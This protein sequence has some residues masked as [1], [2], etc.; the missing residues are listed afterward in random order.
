[1]NDEILTTELTRQFEEKRDT[2][3]FARPEPEP[4]VE[5]GVAAVSDMVGN[6]L[7]Q[8]VVHQIKNNAELQDQMLNTAENCIKTEMQTVA[9]DVDT[10]HKKAVFNN[11]K[12]ACE[13]YGFN[14]E[15]TPIWAVNF[16]KVGYSIILAIWLLVGSFTFM[17]VIFIAKKISVGLKKT[18]L[19]VLI[20]LVLYLGV[21]FVPIIVA[22]LQTL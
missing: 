2:D 3:L 18:W 16:M 4:K 12:D 13:S 9:T 17:P 11:A 19:A 22:L 6:A 5:N 15:T 1:M 20:A 21:T 10:K 7:S 8:A 14:E